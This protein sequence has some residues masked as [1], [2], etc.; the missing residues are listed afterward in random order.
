M[1]K[2][3]KTVWPQLESSYPVLKGI[4]NGRS[5]L[6][7]MGH[8]TKNEET[9]LYSLDDVAIEKASTLKQVEKRMIAD[10]SYYENKEDPLVRVIG[11]E[12]GGRSR[13]ISQIIGYTKVHRG[14]FKNVNH[15]KV[16]LPQVDV[17][18]YIRVD[19]PP[20]KKQVEKRMIA[21][22]SYYENK[23]DPLVRVIGPEH[24]GRSRTIS[25]I[26]GYTKVHRGLFKNVNHDK[27]LLPQ[28]DVRPYIRVDYPPIK[29]QEN[30]VT[31]HV[32]QSLLT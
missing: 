20:I 27:V 10:E 9:K 8:A 7:I 1:R 28:V 25:Q 22:E 30:P 4:L 32:Q 24:G 23:E 19:Y 21:D 16:L 11:P 26:I 3:M 14:L 2:K 13:T 31:E 17:R 6:F 18:P 5:K 15:D 12:H 29:G